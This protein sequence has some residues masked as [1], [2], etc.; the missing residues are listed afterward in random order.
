MKNHRDA[1][2]IFDN[3]RNRCSIGESLHICMVCCK[4][5]ILQLFIVFQFDDF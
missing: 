5:K 2:L 1:K 4:D 3:L